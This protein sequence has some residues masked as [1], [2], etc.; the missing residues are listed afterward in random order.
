[1]KDYTLSLPDGTKKVFNQ[2]LLTKITMEIVDAEG[3]L[4]QDLYA[5]IQKPSNAKKALVEYLKRENKVITKLLANKGKFVDYMAE[6]ILE[7]N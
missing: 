2:E 7:Q 3:V 1:M 6:K 4:A 5:W